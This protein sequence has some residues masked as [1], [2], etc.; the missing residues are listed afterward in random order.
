MKKCLV[1]LLLLVLATPAFALVSGDVLSSNTINYS[2]T[3]GEY[4][5]YTW[6]QGLEG[7]GTT[8][9]RLCSYGSFP[10][11]GAQFTSGVVYLIALSDD[12]SCDG[13]SYSACLGVGSYVSHSSVTICDTVPC[14]GGSP[15]TTTWASSTPTLGDVVF[16]E[17]VII[18]LLS[19]GFIG[20]MFNRLTGRK[21]WR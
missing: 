13:L 12:Y 3:G 2:C 19:L 10:T 15:G 17:A 4:D 18:V 8:F 5:V 6:K 7:S 14:P 11:W 1:C 21:P 16:G 9:N 20:F